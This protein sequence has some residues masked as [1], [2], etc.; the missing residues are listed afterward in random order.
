MSDIPE[1]SSAIIPVDRNADSEKYVIFQTLPFI[2]VS[3]VVSFLWKGKN[4][5]ITNADIGDL[6]ES[7]EQP[8]NEVDGI[9]NLSEEEKL[10]AEESL[11]A[12]CK[13][14]ELYN[15]LQNRAKHRVLHLP[16]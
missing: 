12:Y 2:N 7:R 1:T 3:Q 6:S 10:A 16:L 11:A 5:N 8:N 4:Y 9:E 14:V 13:P 15:Y